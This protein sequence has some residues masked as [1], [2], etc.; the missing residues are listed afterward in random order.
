MLFVLLTTPVATQLTSMQKASAISLS[1]WAVSNFLFKDVVALDRTT[2]IP[3][4]S[5]AQS[6]KRFNKNCWSTIFL[7]CLIRSCSTVL[8]NNSIDSAQS[9]AESCRLGWTCVLKSKP[10]R[11]T[12][13]MALFENSLKIRPKLAVGFLNARCSSLRCDPASE[14]QSKH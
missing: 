7:P 4:V 5:M 1:C 11:P 2:T 14:W 12:E 6:A 9:F 10:P 13:R 8:P 3:Y